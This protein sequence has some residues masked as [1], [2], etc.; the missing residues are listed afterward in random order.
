MEGIA[1]AQHRHEDQVRRTALD[2][3][4]VHPPPPKVLPLGTGSAGMEAL[5]R[6]PGKPIK[7]K[8]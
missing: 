2:P 1:T 6:T 7:V 5:G 8:G 3:C 4:I